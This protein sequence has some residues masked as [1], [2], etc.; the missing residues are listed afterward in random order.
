MGAGVG[1][2]ATVDFFA[3]QARARQ[4]TTVLTVSFALAVAAVVAVVYVALLVTVGTSDTAAFGVGSPSPLQPGLLLAAA[5][6]VATVTGLGSAYHA[7]RLSSGGGDA[8]ASMLGGTPVDRATQD[9]ARRRL[10]NVAEEMAI[11][12][13][14]PVPR[15][16]VL[17]G[18]PGINAFAA[19]YTPGHG[20]VAVTRGALDKLSRDEL[21]G[22]VAHELSHLLNGDTRIDLRL[23]A[24][25]GGLTVLSLLG[26]VILR[27]T[28]RYRSRRDKATGALPLIGLAFLVAG[29]VGAFCGRLVRYA[30][31][32]QREWLADASAV[33][34]TRNPGGLAGA[35]RKIAAEGSLL[36]SPHAPEAAH[37]FFAS[38]V[39]G[40]LGGLFETHPPIA[41]RIRRLE[42]RGAALGTAA[43]PPAPSPAAHPALGTAPLAPLS[44]SPPH[45]SAPPS[46]APMLEPRPS[47]EHVAHAA[48][49]LGG[50]APELAAA[51]R[52]PFGARALACALLIDGSTRRRQLEHLARGDRAL[53][54]EVERLAPALAAVSRRDRLA[55]LGLALPAL[56]ALSHAQSKALAAD[57]RALAAADGAITTFELA[58]FRVVLRRLSRSS[59][60]PPRPRLRSLEDAGPECLELL[61]TLAWIG[62][63][64]E[65]AA[66]AALDEGTRALGAPAPWRL[67]PRERLGL[68]RLDETLTRLD[69]ASAGLK[70]RVLMACAATALSDARI[71]TEEAELVRAVS[72]SLGLAM[73]PVV[74]RGR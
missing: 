50:L 15:L 73:P 21:Q 5:G 37:L 4:R 29:A 64:D 9:P 36:S 14:L 23:M 44:A 12:S 65:A 49:L 53:A 38:G 66:Q 51:A 40:F 60:A 3:A 27:A 1:E 35:L 69:E 61:S 45:P 58:V 70:A 11:A 63:R 57:L 47:P 48:A 31:A 67:L 6:I 20:V 30:V 55:L 39:G 2:R 32:R 33:Q 16:Y 62:G 52:E 74:E 25:V 71:T 19:G 56:D 34:F 26:R 24:A 10:V 59:G 72:A 28:P 43:P 54:A 42:P 46:A 7:I 8:V 41:E 17:E 22:V 18:E 68:G 13:G